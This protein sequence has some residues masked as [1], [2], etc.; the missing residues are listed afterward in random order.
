MT[1]TQKLKLIVEAVVRAELSEQRHRQLEIQLAAANKRLLELQTH[2]A[3]RSSVEKLVVIEAG[4]PGRF[5]IVQPHGETCRK[6]VTRPPWHERQRFT[7][8]DRP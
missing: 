2:E 8:H 3:I 1:K 7:R 5:W 4:P 6:P